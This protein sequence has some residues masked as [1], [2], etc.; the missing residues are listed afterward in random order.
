MCAGTKNG[1]VQFFFF[2]D[3]RRGSHKEGQLVAEKRRVDPWKNWAGSALT[4]GPY[5]NI[6]SVIR[7]RSDKYTPQGGKTG[8]KP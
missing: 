7:V 3:D 4:Q 8:V 2:K 5:L 1:G 6:V